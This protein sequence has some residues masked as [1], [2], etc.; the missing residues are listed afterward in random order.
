MV[1]KKLTLD[2][3][4]S[5]DD[6]SGLLDVKPSVAKASTEASRAQAQFEEIN[7]FVDK[8]GFAPGQGPA[9]RR[10]TITERTLQTRLRAYLDNPALHAAVEGLD[11]HGLLEGAKARPKTL[12]HILDG[13]DDLLD[14]PN[15]GIFEMRHVRATPAK[16]ELVSERVKCED[17]DKFRPLFDKAAAELS[18]GVRRSMRFANEQDIEA[19]TFFILNGVMVYVAEVRDPHVRNGKRNAR[20]RLIFDNETEGNNLLRSLA[21]ELYKDPNGRRISD[22]NPGPL[23]GSGE[24]QTVALPP[25]TKDRVTGLIYVVKSLS[26]HPE[27]TKLDGQLFKIGFTT[28]N[29]DT[30]IRAAV[31][32]P[33]FLMAPVKPVMTYEAINLNANAFERLVH[34]FFAQARLD[35]EIT[36]RFGKPIRPREWFLLPLSIIEQAVPLIVDGSILRYR[37][38]HRACAIMDAKN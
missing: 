31:D 6:G 3:L 26:T 32:D 11:R 1:S 37:Y 30:R 14:D 34:H 20:L 23:F 21:T 38:D 27:I 35:I 33:T 17:F 29:L 13:D 22:P 24:T 28:G 9:E 36:D 4:L 7:A 8:L 2:E 15:A 10:I 25:S 18:S 12:E 19:G 16:A 5:D